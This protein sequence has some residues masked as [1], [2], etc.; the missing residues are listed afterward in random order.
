MPQ[1]LSAGWVDEMAV[2]QR[3]P[4]EAERSVT[5]ALTP[6]MANPAL[7]RAHMVWF[8]GKIDS[9]TALNRQRLHE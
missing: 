6:Q 9:A 8:K 1:W 5:T 7:D 3:L 2:F 4:N